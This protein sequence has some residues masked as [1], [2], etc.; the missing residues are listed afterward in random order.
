MT[1]TTGGTASRPA[2]EGRMVRYLRERAADGEF[3]FKAKFVTDD[4]GLSASQI[5]NLMARVQGS[6]EDLEIERWAYTNATTWRVAPVDD[7]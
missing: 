6:V 3:Y 5:G 2:D 1:E 4:L 7:V